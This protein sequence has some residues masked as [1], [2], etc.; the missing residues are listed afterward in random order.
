MSDACSQAQPA[1]AEIIHQIHNFKHQIVQHAYFKNLKAKTILVLL[2]DHTMWQSN[3]EG[4]SW[5]QIHPEHH[6]LVFYHHKY[7]DDRAYLITDTNTFYATDTGQ[8]WNPA[9]A[10]LQKYL[11]SASHPLPPEHR[12]PHLD[13]QQRL[14]GPGMKLSCRGP[15]L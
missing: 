2:M 11:R 9:R 12:Q 1:P 4:Y 8:T 3:N 5:T 10:R 13:G 6:F 14:L 7:S 15:V